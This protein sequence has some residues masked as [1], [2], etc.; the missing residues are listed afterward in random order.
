[1]L[2]IG[3]TIG[4]L[5]YNGK[6]LGRG[7][8]Y[9][10]EVLLCSELVDDGRAGLSQSVWGYFDHRFDYGAFGVCTRYMRRYGSIWLVCSVRVVD[11]LT[12]GRRLY[13]MTAWW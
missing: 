9:T 12:A 6:S 4:L 8:S 11:E 3:Q 1:M 7:G 13:V 2:V 10:G 5:R